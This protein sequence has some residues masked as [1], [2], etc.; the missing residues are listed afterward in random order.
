M[1]KQRTAKPATVKTEAVEAAAVVETITPAVEQPQAEKTVKFAPETASSINTTID[2]WRDSGN[3]YHAL[4]HYVI[5]QAFLHFHNYGDPVF[6]SRIIN[7]APSS[8]RKESMKTW[9]TKFSPCKWHEGAE[10]A[11]G[12]FKKN[13][14]NGVALY[15]DDNQAG[16]TVI[17]A[18]LASPFDAKP[19]VAPKDFSIEVLFKR[20]DA[21]ARDYNKAVNEDRIEGDRSKLTELVEKVKGFRN[22]LAA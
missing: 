5:R 18:A 20:L 8:A 7:E 16:M 14:A 2:E 15:M 13:K 19:E 9:F 1:A 6:M 21:I 10:G 11:A 3:K 12:K 17:L 4:T 22:T